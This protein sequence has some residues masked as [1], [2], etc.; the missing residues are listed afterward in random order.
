MSKHKFRWSAACNGT[1]KC[2]VCG[3]RRRQKRAGPRGGTI[4]LFSAG[5]GWSKEPPECVASA[6]KRCR[7][8][9]CE[10]EQFPNLLLC[11]GHSAKTEIAAVARM[12]IRAL[13]RRRK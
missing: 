1:A 13:S 3:C 6:G 8:S 4:S 12:A 11:E 2:S 9:G 7:V 10:M 5:S